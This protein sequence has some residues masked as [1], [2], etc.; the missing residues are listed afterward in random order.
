MCLFAATAGFAK[1]PVMSRATAAKCIEE[2]KRLDS[3]ANIENEKSQRQ[4]EQALEKFLCAAN[5]GNAEGAFLAV[6]LSGGGMAPGL[7]DS[8]QRRLMLQA[9][10]GGFSDAFFWLADL[11]KTR[12]SKEALGWL[13]KAKKSDTTGTASNRMAEIFLSGSFDVRDSARAFACLREVGG[14]SSRQRMR[15]MLVAKPT[16]DTSSIC[17]VKP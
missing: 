14:K 10:N 6:D 9:A 15:A 1:D 17:E 13:S 5:E 3:L 12:N 4:F 2:G 16:L 8:L 11:E 7:S